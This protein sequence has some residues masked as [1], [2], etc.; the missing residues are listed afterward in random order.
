[1]C[2]VCCHLNVLCGLSLPYSCFIL[3]AIVTPVFYVGLNCHICVLYWLS[4]SLL[5]FMW[6]VIAISV[7]Y[8]GSVSCKLSLL[9][10]LYGLPLPLLLTGY[11]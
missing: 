7:F 3:A 10:V 6:V 4:L 1:M 2:C 11:A 5:F 9:C 8:I